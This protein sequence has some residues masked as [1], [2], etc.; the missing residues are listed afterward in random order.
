ME[1][2]N[3]I[4]ED[5]VSLEVAKLLKQAG[6]K[7]P[8][9]TFYYYDKVQSDVLIE[10]YSDEPEFYWRPTIE[11]ALKWVEVNFNMFLNVLPVLNPETKQI[12]W[13]GNIISLNFKTENEIL[14]FPNNYSGSKEECLLNLIEHYLKNLV[15]IN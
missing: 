2:N 11:L 9:E 14:K 7:V 10:I 4:K 3:N 6:Y 12:I 5:Y 15:G 13:E 1:L 8:T